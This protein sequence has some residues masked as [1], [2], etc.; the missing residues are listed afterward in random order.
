MAQNSIDTSRDNKPWYKQAWPWFIISIPATSVV[1]G[2]N[3]LYLASTTNNSL[4][5][6]DYYK[7]GKAIN[8]RIERDHHANQLGLS[9]FING[10]E[11]GILLQ[12]EK[13]VVDAGSP[14]VWPDT[15]SM[16][17]IHV[18][19]AHRDGATLLQHIGQGRYLAQSVHLPVDG[20]WRVHVQPAVESQRVSSNEPSAGA[21]W[22]LV[23]EQISF[24]VN[25]EIEI[26][27][28]RNALKVAL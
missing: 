22:R 18:T 21:Y 20:R 6:D 27:T 12:L 8:Q 10:S 25:P 13:D 1:L 7:Q 19:Q 16:R 2:L 11:E 3:L 5:V 23:S 15:L 14:F 4:V 17:W 24:M 26:K 9:A 28:K